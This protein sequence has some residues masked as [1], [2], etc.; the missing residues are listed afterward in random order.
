METTRNFAE[1]IR[2]KLKSNPSLATAVEEARF[3]ANIADEIYNARIQSG[4]TQAELAECAGMKQSAIARL[5]DAD[6]GRHS[7]TSLK[8]IAL[9]LCKRLEIKLVDTYVNEEPIAGPQINIEVQAP[10]SWMKPEKWSFAPPEP[11]HCEVA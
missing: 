4:K 5:E 9:A 10:L 2:Q 1:I 3:N 7:F 6:Y 8:R 11:I